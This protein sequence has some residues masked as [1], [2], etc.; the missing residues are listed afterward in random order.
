MPIT[1]RWVDPSQRKEA[2]EPYAREAES[3]TL[4]L[5]D[6]ALVGS[7][8]RQPAKP[9]RE[10]LLAAAARDIGELLPHLEPR[11]QDWAS[12]ARQKLRERGER[13]SRDLRETLERQRERVL[14]QLGKV[15]EGSFLQLALDFDEDEKRQLEADVRAWRSRLEQF[16]RDLTLQPER[17]REFYS[18]KATRIEPVGLV[19]LWPESN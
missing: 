14:E 7:K 2:L 16:E 5:L 1:A 12:A 17:I 13:E 11:A 8:G 9:V 6:Q 18:V 4:A 3:R 19:Y 15:G 10:K